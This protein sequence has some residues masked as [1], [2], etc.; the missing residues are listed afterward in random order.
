M[1]WDV[2]RARAGRLASAAFWGLLPA[3]AWG[4]EA[5]SVEGIMIGTYQSARHDPVDGLPVRCEGSGALDL[6]LSVPVEDGFTEIEIRAASTPRLMGV[7]SALP[8]VNASLGETVGNHGQGR[9]VAWQAFFEHRLGPGSLA[10]GLIDPAGRLDG[11]EVANNEFTQFLG[12]SFVN[13]LS[14]D[15]PSATLGAVYTSELG[16]GWGLTT[17]VANASGIEP[18]YEQAF[19]LGERG[20][21]GFTAVQLQW[22]SPRLAANLG[23]WGSTRR[24]DDDGDGV[25]DARLKDAPARG[26][27]ANL[28]GPLGHG[29]WSLRLGQADARVQPAARFLGF[30]YALPIGDSLLGMGVARTYASPHMTDPGADLIQAEVYLRV[31]LGRGLTVS[32]DLQYVRHSGLNPAEDGTWA[33]GMRA[34]WSF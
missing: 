8:E 33:V 10:V 16:A 18:D 19:R 27:Y 13:N 22:S 34:G 29:Q 30:A 28:A 1:P 4:A 11:N 21:G 9:V 23:A 17:L 25:D 24:H 31:P 20:N 14:I 26:L 12:A 7:A 6:V 2:A 3:L 5:P 32:P 15:L